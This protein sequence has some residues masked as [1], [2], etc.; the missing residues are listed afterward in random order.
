MGIDIVKTGA[1]SSEL[2]LLPFAPCMP[3][4]QPKQTKLVSLPAQCAASTAPEDGAL[5]DE[6]ITGTRSWSL[7]AALEEERKTS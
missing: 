5:P 4:S 2:T 7:Q 3:H 1:S 6:P